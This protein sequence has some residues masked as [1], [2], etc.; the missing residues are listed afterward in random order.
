MGFLQPAY[1]RCFFML[2]IFYGLGVSTRSKIILAVSSSKIQEHFLNEATYL[3]PRTKNICPHYLVWFLLLLLFSSNNLFFI[4]VARWRQKKVQGH[5]DKL[6]VNAVT[7]GS[8][9]HSF[10]ITSEF[11]FFVFAINKE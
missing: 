3:T 10:K 2:S 5:E 1:A 8:S 7:L 11:F 4:Y 6:K 9:T